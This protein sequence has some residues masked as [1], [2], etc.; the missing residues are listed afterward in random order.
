M[1]I[2]NI[3]KLAGKYL[4]RYKRRYLF[5]FA[6]L[7]FGFGI[8]TTITA[9]KDGM[10]GNVY[11]SARGHHSGDI[12]ITGF[13]E[14][15]TF[16]R[17]LDKYCT[18]TIIDIIAQSGIKTERI[19]KR[20]YAEDGTLFYNGDYAHFKYFTGADWENEKDYF[21]SLD[22]KAGSFSDLKDNS[23]IISAAIADLLNI[24]TGDNIILEIEN[25]KG[26]KNTASFILG[27]VIKDNSVFGYA[28]VF[29]SKKQ[30]DILMSFA[31]GDCSSV[32]VSLKNR[33]DSDDA[34][35]TLQKMISQKLPAAGLILTKED[36]KR[37][38]TIVPD[39]ITVFVMSINAYISEVSQILDALNILIL[40]LYIMMLVIVL[41]SASVTYS[42]IVHERTREIGTMRSIGFS[43]ID[44]RLLLGTETFLL[45]T[46]SI[47]AGFVF[48]LLLTKTAASVSFE[49]L[50]GFEIFLSRGRLSAVHSLPLTIR[51]II[52]VYIVLFLAVFSPTGRVAAS[53]L[54]EMLGR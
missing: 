7:S 48:S 41:V 27:A 12:I 17:H 21:E 11:N 46:I 4:V 35:R 2:S 45:G 44:I 28:K 14:G 34:N 38:P 40:L 30:A 3:I 25:R 36:W 23:I 39:G 42:L 15:G 22:Y 13:D 26:Q 29:V 20:D 43:G 8:I 16:R 9:L 5:L 10:T 19:T 1:N 24:Q 37:E 51:N 52:S 33:K 31:E 6:A 49:W 54:P 32:G 53:P 18:D 47:I 50:P